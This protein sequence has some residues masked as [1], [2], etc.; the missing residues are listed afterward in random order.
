MKRV[1]QRIARAV[2]YGRTFG[3]VRHYRGH[4]VHSPFVYRVVREVVMRKREITGDDRELFDTLRIMGVSRKRSAQLQNLYALCGCG[5]YVV[6]DEWFECKEDGAMWIVSKR[7]D[8]AMLTE[9][10]RHA[11]SHQVVICIVYP[12]SNS[13]RYK[14]TRKAIGEHHGLSID[15]IGFVVLMCNDNRCKQHIYI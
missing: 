9:V 13:K 10:V 8:P 4:G 3:H 6:D 7:V 14:A 5:R 12:R 1:P 11:E 15:S 2:R